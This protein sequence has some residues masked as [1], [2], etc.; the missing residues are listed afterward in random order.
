ML[1]VCNNIQDKVFST[2]TWE[3]KSCE[4]VNCGIIKL[5]LGLVDLKERGGKKP[6]AF[7]CR[8]LRLFLLARVIGTVPSQI[9][10]IV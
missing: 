9:R 7:L 1:R 2:G 8:L 10:G 3:N 4:T 5:E 6:G